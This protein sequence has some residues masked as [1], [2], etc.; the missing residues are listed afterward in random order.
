[1]CI[2][3]R[4]LTVHLE[5]ELSNRMGLG[6]RVILYTDTRGALKQNIGSYGH[7]PSQSTSGL[8]FGLDRDKLRKAVVLWPYA[9]Q[10]IHANKAP[11]R[12]VYDLSHLKFR[13]FLEI[14]LCENGKVLKDIRESCI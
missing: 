9:K 13:K 3:D 2:R 10:N 5:G 14:K 1:M 6:A 4:T 8:H 7:Q 11:H 12:V